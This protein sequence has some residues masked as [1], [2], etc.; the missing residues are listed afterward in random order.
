MSETSLFLCA[1]LALCGTSGEAKDGHFTVSGVSI[2]Y[3]TET[4]ENS[5]IY[6]DD[7]GELRALLKSHPSVDTL[8]LNSGGGS[9]WAGEELARIVLDYE[10]NTVVDGECSSSC[11]DIFLAGQTRTMTRGSTIGFHLSSWSPSAV[12]RYFNT[13]AEEEG[14]SSAFEMG[15]W[16]YSDTQAEV[17]DG[18]N[19]MVSRGV[20]P[21]FAIKSITPR[22]DIWYPLRKDLLE[23]G[24]LTE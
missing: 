19:Y 18:L 17:Y 6:E 7:I 5:E 23:A 16:I 20:D 13:W 10:L 22:D 24:V 4:Q 15:S 1:V 2:I 12:E 11:V 14:W 3:D 9:L 8:V 21:G